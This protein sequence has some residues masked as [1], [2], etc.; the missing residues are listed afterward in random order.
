M[1]GVICLLI[2]HWFYIQLFQNHW[3]S[4]GF[5]VGH[6]RRQRPGMKVLKQLYSL[7]KSTRTLIAKAIGRE[8]SHQFKTFRLLLVLR[9]PWTSWTPKPWPNRKLEDCIGITTLF[10]VF[11][12]VVENRNISLDV[13]KNA[14]SH[15]Q[16]YSKRAQIATVLS[17]FLKCDF[18][19]P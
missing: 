4:I 13:C 19:K 8:K 16:N 7:L 9:R 17:F 18:R 12:A 1:D 3:N 15:Q 6:P 10:Y 2:F 5:T 14:A 11:E